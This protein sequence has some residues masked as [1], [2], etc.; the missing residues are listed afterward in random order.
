MKLIRKSFALILS[1]G[2]VCL[3]NSTPVWAADALHRFTH[4]DQ[5]SLVLGTVA[6]IKEE[7]VVVQVSKTIS[8]QT[9]PGIISVKEPRGLVKLSPND[10]VLL[11]L[12]KADG[13]YKVAWGYCVVSSLDPKNLKVISGNFSKGEQSAIEHYVNSGGKENDFAFDGTTGFLR[14]QDGTSEQIYPPVKTDSKGVSKPQE[15]KPAGKE[16]NV[17]GKSLI[18]SFILIFLSMVLVFRRG[19]KR[20]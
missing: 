15:A 11:S 2:F 18:I 12:D 14:H 17:M 5:D 16:A 4:N 3:F 1:I 13:H 19:G 10:K 20:K 6:A 9:L 7:K 8:G